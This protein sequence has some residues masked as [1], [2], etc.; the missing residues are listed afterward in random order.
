MAKMVKIRFIKNYT[1]YNS[2]ETASYTEEQAKYYLERKV[3]V[4]DRDVT[5][6]EEHNITEEKPVINETWRDIPDLSSLKKSELVDI[7]T[8]EGISTTGLNKG[9]I[10][11]LLEQ[12]RAF[13][14]SSDE[15]EEFTF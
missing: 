15:E 4:L 10:V 14:P 11:S 2:G 9:D 1:P 12:K 6:K 5:V 8:L 3:S 7:A 13:L